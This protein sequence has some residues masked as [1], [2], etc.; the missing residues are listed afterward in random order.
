MQGVQVGWK[1]EEQGKVTRKMDHGR[2][3]ARWITRRVGEKKIAI[4]R[5]MKALREGTRY[6]DGEK[7][8]KCCEA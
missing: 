1:E 2:R 8:E 5:P 3:S 7:E 6:A 4:R